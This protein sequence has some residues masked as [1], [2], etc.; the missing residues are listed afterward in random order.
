MRS[1]QLLSEAIIETLKDFSTEK[2]P[3]TIESLTSALSARGEISSLLCDSP[4]EI[5]DSDGDLASLSSSTISRVSLKASKHVQTDF[6]AVFRQVLD[7]LKV[8]LTSLEPLAREENLHQASELKG[9]IDHCHSVESLAA[10]RDEIIQAVKSIVNRAVEQ[11]DFANDFLSE[12][13]ENLSE[14]EKQLFSYQNLNRE[15]FMLQGQ[16]CDD[17]LTQTKEMDHAVNSAKALEDTRQIISSR[18][19][20]I[21]KAIEIKRQ[22]DES[23][24][25]EADSTI[26]ELQVSVRNY[27]EEINQ[28]TKRAIALEKEVLLDPLLE[29]NNR[30]AYDLK[31][32]ESIRNYHRTRE[33]FSLIL[34]DVDHFKTVNDRFGHHAGDKCLREI[35]KLIEKSLR[36]TDF[37]ARYGGEELVVILSG[38]DALD[39]RK[40][41]DKI[42][43]RID[44]TRFYYQDQV[45]RLTISLGV[46]EVQVTDTDPG[47]PFVRVDEAMYHAK[48]EGRNRVCVV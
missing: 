18:L 41:A 14:M 45:I 25:K 1:L 44:K 8:I 13:S 40:I 12:L 27:N 48:R 9:R 36:K 21:G 28:V 22:E 3:L 7:T 30:R 38:S 16:F 32:Q 29:I 43:D 35:A 17:L 15:T 11:I 10:K 37:L 39:A 6:S 2:R 47:K 34:V 24:R 23:R 33:P 31:I 46:T 19:S 42:R 4:S 5:A 20:I 26:A